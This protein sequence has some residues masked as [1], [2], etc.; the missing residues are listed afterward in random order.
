MKNQTSL[1]K[2]K[3]KQLI[4]QGTRM[5]IPKKLLTLLLTGCLSVSAVA[6]EDPATAQSLADACAGCHGTDGNS[7]GPAT[8][9]LAGISVDYFKD[10]MASFKEQD[11]R[12]S[13]IMGRIARGYSEA[14]IALMA[15]YFSRQTFIAGNQPFDP[16]LAKKGGKLHRKYC[17]KCHEDGGR[18]TEDD[19]GIL[20]GQ[21]MDYLRYTLDDINN[22]RRPISRKM[23]KKLS[24][25]EKSKGPEALEALINYYGSQ[26]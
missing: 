20:A 6:A 1:M 21:W 19:T 8:P 9:T 17:E 2:I 14:E 16:K 23:K 7:H 5:F 22:G 26:K 25:L 18:S 12:Y 4:I 10:N 3:A 24:K 11:G 15:E 13:T